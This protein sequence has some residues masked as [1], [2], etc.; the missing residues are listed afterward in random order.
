MEKKRPDL[1]LLDYEMPE[2]NGREFLETIRFDA[3]YFDIPVIFL[4]AIA[5]KAHIAAVLELEP[6]GYFLKPMRKDKVL[7]KIEEILG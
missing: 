7:E 5:D 3:D 2:M 1:I 4:T 6:A